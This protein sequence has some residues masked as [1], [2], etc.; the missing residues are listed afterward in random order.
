[1]KTTAL[2]ILMALP[3]IL[4]AQSVLPS[5]N[6]ESLY[7]LPDSKSRSVSPE[8]LTGEKGKG[9]MATLENGSA[10]YNARELG[11]GWKVNPYVVI[12]PGET[13]TMADI[14]GPGIIKH[15]WMTPAGDYRLSIFR[16][17]WD[18]EEQP[19][20]ES[21]VGDFFCTA[22]GWDNEPQINSLAVCVNPKNGFNCYWPMPFRKRCRITMQNMS[23]ERLVVYY[24]VDYS[25]TKVPGDAAY[26]HARFNRTN[27]VAFKEDYTILDG[28]IGKGQ[29]VGT[30]IAHGAN[31]PWW[32]GEGEVK[33]FIDG[34]TKFPTICG[35]GEEDYFNGSYCYEERET[36]DTAIDYTD[37]S[38]PY[39]GFYH[40]N[41]GHKDN[42]RRFGEYRWHLTDPIRFDKDLKVT[43]QCIGWQSEGRYLPL[44]DDMASVAYWYQTEPH[45]PFQP[46]PSKEKLM[47]VPPG[48]VVH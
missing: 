7:M 3:A 35:T 15:I 1:M 31:S 30:F 29:Y 5:G 33:F 25:E 46:L 47:I 44:T 16:I 27:P 38:S 13:F 14:A 23:A 10:A 41:T 18:D 6:L 34:D 42:Q 19:S 26:F 9:G 32:W 48:K 28:V 37:F 39:T 36:P 24:Q 22:W 43:I 8:N 17:Y 2:L 45:S 11:Q 20:V 40:I 21:P 12:K 4:I